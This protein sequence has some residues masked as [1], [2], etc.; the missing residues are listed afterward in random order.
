MKEVVEYRVN[1]MES[2]HLVDMWRVM[3]EYRVQEV[4]LLNI[5]AEPA[6]VTGMFVDFLSYPEQ[7]QR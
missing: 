2:Y 6:I 4:C 7:R 3:T 1:S 5:S